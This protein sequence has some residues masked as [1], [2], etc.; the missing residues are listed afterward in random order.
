[1]GASLACLFNLLKSLTVLWRRVAANAYV[2]P[3][4]QDSSPPLSTRT[5]L[6]AVDRGDRPS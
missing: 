4:T 5:Q 6:S 2:R 3:E 1:M